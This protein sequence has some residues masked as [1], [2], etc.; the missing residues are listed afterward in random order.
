MST[1]DFCD[2][3]GKETTDVQTGAIHGCDDADRDGNGTTSDSFDQVCLECYRAW[4]AY[5]VNA[6]TKAPRTRAT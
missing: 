2:V 5:M 4:K 6:A 3:C 1:R